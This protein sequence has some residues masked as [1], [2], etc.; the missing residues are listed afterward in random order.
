MFCGYRKLLQLLTHRC[1][2]W[3]KEC[4]NQ[5][6]FAANDHSGESLEPPSLGHL[7]FSRQPIS[8]QA[9]LI[10]RNMMALDAGQKMPPE[11]PRQVYSAN[12]RHAFNRRKIPA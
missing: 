9:K 1:L 12:A 3:L 10:N 11:V 8:E 4:L 2:C 6:T 7:R 5:F